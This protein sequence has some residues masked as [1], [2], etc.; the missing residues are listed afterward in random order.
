MWEELG[1]L[2]PPRPPSPRASWGHSEGGSLA[3][4]VGRRRGSAAGR[5]PASRWWRRKRWGRQTRYPLSVAV[6]L[7][8]TP[9]RGVDVQ[10]QRSGGASWTVWC[11]GRLTGASKLPAE[12]GSAA[13]GGMSTT[14]CVEPWAGR[15]GG[16]VG[17]AGGSLVGKV[18][19][20]Q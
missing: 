19:S 8:V 13:L 14:A 9:R 20:R 17:L 6:A 12:S 5:P 7:G 4:P 2:R 16:E 3:Q 11:G 15:G 10:R 18:S 1:R